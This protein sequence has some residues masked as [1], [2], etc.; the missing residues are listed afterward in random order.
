MACLQGRLTFYNQRQSLLTRLFSAEFALW[1]NQLLP[2]LTDGSVTAGISLSGS[3][4]V[5]GG[6]ASGSAGNVLGGG[7]AKI[8]LVPAGRSWTGCTESH[9]G[10][11]D[12]DTAPA[13]LPWNRS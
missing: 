11:L 9:G 3:V 5:K 4:S 2:G 7:L 13:S 8:I 12:V 1:Y 6:K 10:E